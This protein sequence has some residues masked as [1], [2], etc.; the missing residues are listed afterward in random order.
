MAH[1]FRDSVWYDHGTILRRVP[2][3]SV[4]VSALDDGSTTVDDFLLDAAPVTVQRYARFLGTVGAH[5]IDVGTG[6]RAF[7]LRR[8]SGSAFAV[9]SERTGTGGSLEGVVHVLGAP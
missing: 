2:G 6:G 5:M 8:G 7:A 1:P 3:G 9:V 4:R